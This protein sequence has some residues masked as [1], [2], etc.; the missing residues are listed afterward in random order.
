MQPTR[1]EGDT[2]EQVQVSGFHATQE[3]AQLLSALQVFSAMRLNG[4]K[5]YGDHQLLFGAK[6]Q[7]QES[8]QVREK[9]VCLP[10]TVTGTRSLIQRIHK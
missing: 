1:D 7:L 9:Q 8:D 6:V 10:G 4:G 2:V 3:R 5:S